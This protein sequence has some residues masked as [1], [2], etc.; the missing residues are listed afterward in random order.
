M[1]PGR[2]AAGKIT[3]TD[4]GVGLLPRAD[5]ARLSDSPFPVKLSL[6]WLRSG[7]PVCRS[8]EKTEVS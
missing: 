7:F 4:H 1:K 5:L 6:S 2:S 3:C 8:G